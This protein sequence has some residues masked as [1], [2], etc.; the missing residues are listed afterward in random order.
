MKD[1]K[2]KK[3]N[4]LIFIT[5]QFNPRY[6]GYA[7]HPLVKTPN[8]DRIA[9]EGVNFSRMY[10]SEP[11]C[12]PARATMFTGLTPRGHRVRMNGIPLDNSIPTFTEALLKNGY[13][14]YSAGKIHLSPNV[15]PKGIDPYTI[16]PNDAPE[17]N[18]LWKN[19]K[20]KSLP[21]PYYGL[22][23]T[24]CTTGHGFGTAGDYL[25]WLRNEHPSALKYF[26]EKSSLETIALEKPS[27]VF[28][29]FN[30]NS[31]KWALPLE[32]HPA[33]WIADR[34]ID[35]LNSRSKNKPFL[36]MCSFQ[37]PHPPFSPPASYC[38][39]YKPEDMPEP[40]RR[41][42]E[43]DNLPPHFYKMYHESIITSGNKA[44]PMSLT[45]P[46]KREITA[47][48]LGLIEMVDD[49]V[50]RVMESLYANNMQDDTVVIF[51]ADHG[52]AMG[53]HGMW[54]KGPYHFDSVIRVPFLVSYPGHFAQG[55]VYNAPAEMIDFAPT[56]LDI[57]G[58]PIPEYVLP[59]APA[60]AEADNAPSAWP[61]KSLLPILAEQGLKKISFEETALVEMDEDYLNFKMRTLVTKRYRLTVYSGKEYGELFDLQEDPKEL[62]NL[63]SKPDYRNIKR[64][65]LIQLLDK[66]IKTDISI[67]KQ[68]SRA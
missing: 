9:H 19:G 50:G 65:L 22:E 48:Y 14:T 43:Y 35:F 18:I 6:L 40:Y 3:P 23:S 64:D 59:P 44:E 16:D 58:V 10:T 26:T 45:E 39:R 51:I 57:A 37:E 32:L 7:G 55:K 24:N 54:G 1:R 15:T 61:G 25:N 42:G 27:G 4:F 28:K 36:A 38:S 29:L 49:Q 2:N 17:L 5:D 67:P 11:L 47:H 21:L 52:E 12:M 31:F 41:E 20:I 13:N 33:H 68:T 34:T 60:K 63:W 66:I 56:I 30:R 46:Y 62:W 8:I 53:D